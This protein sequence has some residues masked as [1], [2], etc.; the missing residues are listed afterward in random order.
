MKILKYIPVLFLSIV[1]L[2]SC[3]KV[4][5]LDLNDVDKKIVVDGMVSN[6]PEYNYIKLTISDDFYQTADFENVT[7]AIV[8]IT[9][10][11]GTVY[12]L[13][14]S[15]PGYYT[16]SLW[17]GQS[18]TSY[19]LSIE[20]NGEV[21]TGSTYLPGSAEIDSIVTQESPPLFGAGEEDAFTAFLYWTD[22]ASEKS[23]YRIRTFENGLKENIIYVS[24]DGLYNG[25]GTGQPLFTNS[26]SLNDTAMVELMEIDAATYEYWFSLSQISSAQNQPAAPGNPQTNLIGN[27]LGY[28][29][30]YNVDI[31][32]VVVQ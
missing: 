17:V 20:A 2:S 5:E 19:Q 28:F 32:T 31:D 7:G 9:D 13:T 27:A 4:I 21:I 22:D 18:Y 15:A 29:G 12:S 1:A 16:N 14:E 6:I 3:T 30:G 10:Q 26:Y 24:N 25:L 11:S 23:Y 8:S